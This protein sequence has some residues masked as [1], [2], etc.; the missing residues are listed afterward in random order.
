MSASNAM[1]IAVAIPSGVDAPEVLTRDFGGGALTRAALAGEL[2]EGWYADVPC[3]AAGWETAARAVAA[4]FSGRSWFVSL[5]EALSASGPAAERLERVARGNGVV[6]TTGQQPGLFGGPIYT[7]SKA[8]SA[9]ALA[10][11]IERKTGIPTAPVFWA[12]TDDADFTEASYT[13]VT[14]NGE[15]RE[16]RLPDRPRVASMSVTSLGQIWHEYAQFAEAAGS[17]IDPHP[18][19]AVRSAYTHD[20]TVGHAYVTLL[21][22]LFE[23]LGIAVLDAAH[24]AV[25]E[26][27]AETVRLALRRADVVRDALAERSAAIE[28]AGYKVQVQPVPNLSLVFD[29]SSGERA[30]VPVKRSA[31]VAAEANAADIGPNV[32]LRPI[33]ERQILPTVAYVAG[34][35]EYA[36][37]AQLS[38]IADTLG[39]A[40]PRVV[41][42]WSGLI[43][44]PQVREVLRSID[45]AV[46]DFRDPHAV[47][48]RVAREE[49]PAGVRDAIAGL[50]ESVRCHSAKMR[51]RDDTL[52]VLKKAIGGFE[53]QVVYRID[54][55]ERR[56]AAAV[57][58]SDNAR[59]HDVAIARSSLF[60]NGVPQERALNIIPFL[61]RYGG[62]LR[63]RMIERAHEHARAL[64]EHG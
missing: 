55:L 24:P 1:A 46:D 57:K 29:S 28:Q 25:R 18:L 22:T 54:R 17:A 35:A 49:L 45:A 44:E 36:Y 59:L 52:P 26:A 39:V 21:R 20:N 27:S 23:P 42:R 50:R 38:A 7:W 11:E 61:A 14:L 2:P 63:D 31:A 10:N 16:I 37:F 32:L 51:E 41:P 30:R 6:V 40:K 47:E 60:P 58:R 48:G 3:D 64:V 4:E 33:V 9:L 53:S 13:V 15:A 34:P 43:V 62:V 19:E 12:A 8:F 56:Y 5:S